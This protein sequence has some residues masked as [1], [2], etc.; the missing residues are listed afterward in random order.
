MTARY[1][2]L[3]ESMRASAEAVLLMFMLTM[4]I[5]L[6]RFAIRRAVT[7]PVVPV[8]FR[9][10]MYNAGDLLLLFPIYALIV[11]SR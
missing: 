5:L 2:L 3:I 8:F 6:V 7:S 11:I 4:L 10:L 9:D 1:D